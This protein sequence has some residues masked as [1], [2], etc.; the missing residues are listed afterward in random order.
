MEPLHYL[1]GGE[2][3]VI[4]AR[5][6]EEYCR[7][8]HSMQWYSQRQQALLN[9][10]FSDCRSFV[11]EL[12]GMPSDIDAAQPTP[13]EKVQEIPMSMK[14]EDSLQNNIPSLQDNIMMLQEH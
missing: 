2:H 10:E 11:P 8:Y 13:N 1:P 14:L 5:Q 12:V 7:F 3:V 9:Y 6:W 4:S